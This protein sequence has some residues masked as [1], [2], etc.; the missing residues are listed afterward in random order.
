MRLYNVRMVL[1]IMILLVFVAVVPGCGNNKE[2]KTAASSQPVS[3]RDRAEEETTGEKTSASAQTEPAKDAV[4]AADSNSNEDP[5]KAR[6][7][8]LYE[9]T[10]RRSEEIGQQLDEGYM[11]QQTMN[12]TMEED[13][14]NWDMLLNQIWA[15]LKENLDED[16]M[17][18]L[19]EQQKEWITA[20]EK[21]VEEKGK[22]M[23]G[24]SMQPFLEYGEAAYWTKTK[25]KEL[26]E[27]YVY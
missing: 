5:A 3:T 7:I 1:V 9:K 10:Q 2:Q 16:E 24:G 12:R 17:Q 23:E 11:D 20:K 13:Y 27:T 4:T 14:N 26:M 6:L 15:Y 21:A 22:E 8:S 19:T 18:T 25:A